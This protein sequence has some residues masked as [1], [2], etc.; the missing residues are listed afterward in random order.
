MEHSVAEKNDNKNL[1]EKSS[2]LWGISR[3]WWVLII[4]VAMGYLFGKDLALK[5]NEVDQANTGSLSQ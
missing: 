5:H 4:V 3:Y 1:R 2:G